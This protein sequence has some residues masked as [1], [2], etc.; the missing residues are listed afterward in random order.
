MKV[1]KQEK[2]NWKTTRSRRRSRGGLPSQHQHEVVLRQRLTR[3]KCTDRATPVNVGLTELLTRM[4]NLNVQIKPPC[5]CF[6]GERGASVRGGRNLRRHLVQQRRLGHPHVAQLHR[7]RGWN[8]SKLKNHVI[9]STWSWASFFFFFFRIL[10]K[11]WTR[12]YWSS[13]TKMHQQVEK[14]V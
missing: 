8:M 4:W 14:T 10:E 7:G 6:S 3:L 1:Q 9:S 12:I 11:E 2:V 5:S 13:N